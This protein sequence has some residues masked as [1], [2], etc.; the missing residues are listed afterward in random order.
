MG[1]TVG[2]RL[3]RAY[4]HGKMES[5]DHMCCLGLTLAERM[6][7]DGLLA[8]KPFGWVMKEMLRTSPKVG[9]MDPRNI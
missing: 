8:G 5:C 6:G 2:R 1:T 7:Q 4:K 3:E 9:R